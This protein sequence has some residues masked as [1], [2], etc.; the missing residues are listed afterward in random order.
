M[1]INMLCL[2]TRNCDC[3]PKTVISILL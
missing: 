1:Y 2:L 3:E